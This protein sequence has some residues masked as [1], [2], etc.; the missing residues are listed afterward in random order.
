MCAAKG[1]QPEPESGVVSY[2]GECGEEDYTCRKCEGN[3]NNDDD[4]KGK[5][6]KFLLLRRMITGLSFSST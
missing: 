5:D 2:V 3:C 6:N 4:C 1:F